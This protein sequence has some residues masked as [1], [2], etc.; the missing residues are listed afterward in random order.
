MSDKFFFKGRQDARQSNLKY[1]YQ[2]DKLHKAGSKKY[3]L[4]LVVTSE[5]RKKEV[6]A[7]V[8]EANLHA[9]ITLNTEPSTVESI[10]ELTVI[11]NK[12]ESVKVDS[13]PGR[14]D[15]CVCGSGKKYKKCCG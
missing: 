2:P 11:L 1:G 8:A 4:K 10:E 15:P 3:P 13:T 9:E 5:Q 7:I 12:S 14:N 6:E